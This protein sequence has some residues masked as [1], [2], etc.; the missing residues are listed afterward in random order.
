MLKTS[1]MFPFSGERTNYVLADSC[2]CQSFAC[3]NQV[4]QQES[5]WVKYAFD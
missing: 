5:A 1:F 2:L 3:R 4:A